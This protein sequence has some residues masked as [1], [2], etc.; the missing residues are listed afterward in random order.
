MNRSVAENPFAAGRPAGADKTFDFEAFAAEYG[1][2]ALSTLKA[3]AVIYPQ[4]ETAD[5]LFYI[6]TGRVQIKLISPEGKM[7]IMAILEKDA[8]FGETCLLGE[9]TRVATA[10]CLADC[11]LVRVTKTAAIR[12]MQSDTRFAE[13]L[14][15]RIL[16]RVGRLRGMLISHLFDTSEQ[17]LARTLLMLANYGRGNSGETT[18]ENLD[19]EE[20]AQMVGTTR[21]RISHFMNKFRKLGYIDY[22]GHIAVYRSLS[23]V[24]AAGYGDP[25]DLSPAIESR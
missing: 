16:H 15:R 18:I 23:N 10:S 24:L 12:A 2:T 6:R 8:V 22:N 4:G 21:A 17:R 9:E 19:Q 3:G 20:L 14:L 13:F 5:C 1:G 7:A 25:E 11:V